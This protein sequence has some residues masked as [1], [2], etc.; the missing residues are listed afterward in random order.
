MDHTFLIFMF[1]FYIHAKQNA[2]CE[3]H[4]AVIPNYLSSL[5]GEFY[6]CCSHVQVFYNCNEN[7]PLSFVFGIINDQ[8]ASRGK[9]KFRKKEIAGECGWLW[10]PQIP[11]YFKILFLLVAR[12]FMLPHFFKDVGQSAGKRMG[13]HLEATADW[14]CQSDYPLRASISSPVKKLHS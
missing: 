14:L 13:S 5:F 10:E 6:E 8:W 1:I 12:V 2:L 4:R 7:G 9:Q 3:P 11:A